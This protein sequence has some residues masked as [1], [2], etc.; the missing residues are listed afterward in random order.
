MQKNI[1]IVIFGSLL[2]VAIV[3]WQLFANLD[4]I[5]AGT[6]VD[7]GS[8]V[9]KTSVTVS[10]VSIDLGKGKAKIAGITV[11]NP[12]GYSSANVFELKAIEVDLDLSSVGKDVLVIES[13]V[14]DRPSILFE[15]DAKGGSNMQTLLDNIES[16]PSDSTSANQG[17]ANRM[18]INSFKFAGGRVTA[19]TALKPGEAAEFSLP[20]IQMTDIGKAEGG[21]TADVV[22]KQITSKLVSAIIKEAAKQSL[23]RVIEKKSKGILDKIYKNKN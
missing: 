12:A 6:I 22:A 2:L 18:I 9:L 1:L 15:G 23:T 17:E 10:G 11:A 16:T 13:I 21:V 7:V 5:V 8:D 19:T 4:K 3:I 14:V 20:A